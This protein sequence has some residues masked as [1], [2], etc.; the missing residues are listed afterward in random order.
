VQLQPPAP[1]G[2]V[3]GF[4]AFHPN[5][6]TVHQH[7]QEAP[8]ARLQRQLLAVDFSVVVSLVNHRRRQWLARLQ[9]LRLPSPLVAR[10]RTRLQLHQVCYSFLFTVVSLCPY[11]QP[12]PYLVLLQPVKRA[13]RKLPH[14]RVSSKSGISQSF[15]LTQSVAAPSFGLFGAKPDEKKDTGWISQ[16]Y[17]KRLDLTP[18]FSIDT[19]Y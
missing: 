9:L 4:S 5:Q 3:T 19:R 10:R 1:Q 6:Q 2:R 15:H 18:T 13:R 16:K 8:Q 17:A 12:L 14:Q 7:Q 11:L